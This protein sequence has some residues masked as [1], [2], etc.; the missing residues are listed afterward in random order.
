VAVNTNGE[1]FST[2]QI[3]NHN[4]LTMFLQSFVWLEWKK[5]RIQHTR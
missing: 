4:K 2:C 1:Q 3:Q 5:M